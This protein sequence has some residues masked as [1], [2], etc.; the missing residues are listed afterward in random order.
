MVTFSF[1]PADESTLPEIDASVSTRV[2]SWKDAAEMND[3]VDNDAFVIPSSSGTA[4]RRLQVLGGHAL[5]LR[6]EAVLVHLLVDEE[7]GVTHLLDPHP[8]HHLRTTT[9]MCLSL[10]ATPCNRYTSWISF[11]R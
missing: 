5:V 9:S 10:M 2:V 8:A 7:L 3:S 1:R 6:P 4:G 11:T